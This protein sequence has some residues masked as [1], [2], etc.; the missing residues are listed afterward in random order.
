MRINT[1]KIR[2]ELSKAPWGFIIGIIYQLLTG[3]F[4]ALII[5]LIIQLAYQ[6]GAQQLIN[7][8]RIFPLIQKNTFIGRLVLI[9]HLDQVWQKLITKNSTWSKYYLTLSHNHLFTKNS[10]NHVL[11]FSLSLQ[12]KILYQLICHYQDAPNSITA[13]PVFTKLLA[14]QPDLCLLMIFTQDHDKAL[15]MFNAI[16]KTFNF[17]TL[18]TFDDKYKNAH[19]KTA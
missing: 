13:C 16:Q 2:F 4:T 19:I 9:T 5:G 12:E 15:K 6:I 7:S 3:S 14:H 8:D 10:Q 17:E 11:F 18:C 1:H